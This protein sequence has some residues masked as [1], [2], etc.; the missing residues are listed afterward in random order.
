MVD[1]RVNRDEVS[2]LAKIF[3]LAKSAFNREYCRLWEFEVRPC[4]DEKGWK[5]LEVFCG[6][7]E[8]FCFKLQRRELGIE[9]AAW[10][11]FR[12]QLVGRVDYDF[13]DAMGFV[14][15]YRDLTR[16]I[17]QAIAHLYEFHGDS[18]G[19][20][21]DAYP[22]AGRELVERALASHPKSAQP[23]RVGY[24][25]EG[26]VREAVQEKLGL[27]WYKL[28]CEGPNYVNHAL[29]VACRKSYL[30]RILTG[31]DSLATWTEEEQRS[32]EFASHYGD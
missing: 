19:D 9:E 17:G 15:W 4:P 5:L 31:M 11:M 20:L 14:K 18:F 13:D 8:E 28:I 1:V 7:V 29:E 6:A 27:S 2:R 23:R 24:L 16:K 12:L 3:L 21:I 22:L 30:H 32:V 26:E 10:E 25:D